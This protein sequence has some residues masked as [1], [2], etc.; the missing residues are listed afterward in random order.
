MKKYLSLFIVII[1]VCCDFSDLKLTLVNN[2]DKVI[3]FQLS[4][5]TI[6]INDKEYLE[7]ENIFPAESVNPHFARGGDDR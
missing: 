7:S 3:Y 4:Y 2:T 6:I 1:F 5:D